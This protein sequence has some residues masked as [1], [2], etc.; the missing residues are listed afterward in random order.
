V[1]V[2]LPKTLAGR[3]EVDVVL[4]VDGSAANTVRLNIK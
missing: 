1:N 4:S 3:G 2:L